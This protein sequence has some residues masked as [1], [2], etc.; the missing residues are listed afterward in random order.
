[1]VHLDAGPCDA[2]KYDLV[3]YIPEFLAALREFRRADGGDYDLIHSHYWLS[4]QA[5]ATLSR[6][7]GRPHFVTFHTLAKTKMRARA[8]EREPAL[9]Q[10]IETRAMRDADRIIVSTREELQD[11]TRLYGA[12]EGKVEIVPAGVDLSAFAPVDRDAARR[13]L[14]IRERG[15]LLYVGRIEPLKG[16][17]ILLRA[18]TLMECGNDVRLF[19]VGG[20]AGGDAEMER[21]KALAAELGIADSVT[22]T[23]S[24]P[25]R[26]LPTYYSAA[27]AFVLPSHA[28]SFGLAALEAM[29]CGVPVVVSRVGGLK[30]FI[31]SGVSGY[32]VPWRCPEAFAQRLDVLLASPELRDSMG[33]AA[34]EKALGM[35]W[36]QAADR[37]LSLYDSA[38]A[39][40]AWQEAA[41]G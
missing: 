19:V 23:G 8:G 33:R 15:A 25:Q 32:L 17:E 16:I 30:T 38:T 35:G 13:A 24:V 40:R 39:A 36:N 18:L 9:R 27:D 28:E 3:N 22:F 1:M 7:W 5:G 21:L 37:T 31:D 11:V 20:D 29:A 4:A 14:G 34:R 26:D 6:E 12:P 41:G 2:G 10:R